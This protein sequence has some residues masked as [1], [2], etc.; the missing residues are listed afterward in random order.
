MCSRAGGQL[1]TLYRLSK[2]MSTNTIKAATSSF[3]MSN[4]NYCPLVWHFTTAKSNK[5]IEKIQERAL[6]LSNDHNLTYQKLLTNTGKCTMELCRLKYL[7]IEIYK[8]LNGSNPSYMREI[9]KKT[10]N[11]SSKRFES[12]IYPAHHN[13]VHFGTKSLRVLGP[14]IWNELPEEIRLAE[15]L[16]TFK[17]LIH[18]WEGKRCKCKIC[19]YKKGLQI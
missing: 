19:K 2:F 18:N 7:C 1:N 15:N 14:Q 11:R 5:K 12:H 10:G 9:F 17:R 3:V 6:R 4:F 16:Q 8:T 13:Q